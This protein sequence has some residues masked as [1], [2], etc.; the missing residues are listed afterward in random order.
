M[1]HLRTLTAFP[2]L[3]G[4]VALVAS[5]TFVA[6]AGT[7]T[8]NPIGDGNPSGDEVE[9]INQLEGDCEQVVTELDWEEDW[10]DAF[11][12][13]DVASHWPESLTT[14][15]RWHDTSALAGGPEPGLGGLEL[16]IQPHQVAYSV[17]PPPSDNGNDGP[18]TE[19][20]VDTLEPG[21]ARA[22]HV[23]ATI[24]VKSSDGA[25]D[26]LWL[27]PFVTRMNEDTTHAHFRVP[28]ADLVGDFE[29][30]VALPEGQELDAPLALEVEMWLSPLGLTGV[31][32]LAAEIVD[33]TGARIDTAPIELGRFPDDQPCGLGS[34]LVEPGQTFHGFSYDDVL[35]RLTAASGSEWAL[36]HQDGTTRLSWSLPSAPPTRCVGAEQ[37]GAEFLTTLSVESDDGSVDGSFIVNVYATANGDG[38]YSALQMAGGSYEQDIA[39]AQD[40]GERY[41]LTDPAP[42]D[43]FT[44]GMTDFIVDVTGEPWG[45]FRYAGLTQDPCNAGPGQGGCEG[46][47][48]T[49]LFGA[50]LGEPASGYELE[51]ATE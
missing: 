6:C 16:T 5:F 32:R 47:L 2:W 24:G 19:G 37:S 46:M 13:A 41:A 27:V 30:E 51:P 11:S 40:L 26:E 44:G 38:T 8:G 10:N 39:D 20:P 36:E 3:A 12:G 35:E 43:G 18:V 22:L 1:T 33:E 48:Q 50:H 7:D 34:Y 14:T 4:S 42:L 29:A 17:A 15:L 49:V 23:E 28:V 9:I 31:L 45:V 21:C 25:L